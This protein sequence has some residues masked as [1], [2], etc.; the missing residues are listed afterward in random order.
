MSNLHPRG[1]SSCAI[2]A[3]R[4]VLGHV[5]DSGGWLVGAGVESL[6][7][8]GAGQVSAGDGQGGETLKR[9]AQV[10][11]AAKIEGKVDSSCEFLPFLVYLTLNEVMCGLRNWTRFREMNDIRKYLAFS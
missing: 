1:P 3:A 7:P 2:W 6:K 8:N 9:K 10:Q 5:V 11:E 4:S